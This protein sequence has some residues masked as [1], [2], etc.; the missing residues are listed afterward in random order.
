[1]CLIPCFY[2]HL[3]ESEECYTIAFEDFY[4]S[5]MEATR[6]AEEDYENSQQPQH[7]HHHHKRMSVVPMQEGVNRADI[8]WGMAGVAAGQKLWA[9]LAG[10]CRSGKTKDI[11][12][13]IQFKAGRKPLRPVGRPDYAVDEVQDIDRP[14]SNLKEGTAAGA[15]DE[16]RAGE[17]YPDNGSDISWE[18]GFLFAST[19]ERVDKQK[20]RRVTFHALG[21]DDTD[22]IDETLQTATHAPHAAHTARNSEDESNVNDLDEVRHELED[23][24]ARLST[25]DRKRSTM[26]DK[27]ISMRRSLVV[28][29]EKR[30]NESVA[31][32]KPLM[33][34]KPS[35]AGQAPKTAESQA[36]DD[37]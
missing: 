37:E 21:G 31:S 33:N 28:E 4:I 29:V 19:R 5:H 12:S 36:D 2:R 14:W 25:A 17:D 9:R 24:N 11:R 13:V 15:T 3:W 30:K 8:S 1:L 35:V 32:F 6:R 34:K 16:A 22:V 20:S 10:L 18:E 23:G 26:K 7:E 27:D